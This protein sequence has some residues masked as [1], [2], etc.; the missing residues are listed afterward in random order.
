[1]KTG[2][3]EEARRR[4]EEEKKKSHHLARVL[5]PQSRSSSGS[6][7]PLYPNPPVLRFFSFTFI[8]AH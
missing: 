8:N 4:S 1:M 6:V 5:S 2:R 7:L 3:S